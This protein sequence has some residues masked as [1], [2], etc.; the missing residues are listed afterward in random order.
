VALVR[1]GIVGCGVI[2]RDYAKRIAAAERLELAGA[3][4]LEPERADAFAAEHGCRSYATLDEL[5]ADPAIELV[6]NV[7]PPQAHATVSAAALGAG[8]HVHSEKPLALRHE[9]AAALV[10]QA[11]RQ[12][13]RLSCAPATLLGEAQQTAWKLVREGA[14]GT[15]RAV[16]A[17]ANWGRIESWHPDPTAL[18]AVGPLVDVG[19]Y[20]IALVTAMLGPVRRVIAHGA[21]LEPERT[22]R[23]GRSFR[24]GAPDFVVAT[25]ELE[26]GTAV[27]VTASFYVGGS[28]QHGLELHGD[29]GSLHLHDWAGGDSAV[30]LR[31]R[32]GDYA[33]VPLVRPATPGTDWG[34]PLVDLAEAVESGRP[35]RTGAEHAAHV[36]EI[37][38]A[39]AESI[40]SGSAVP[41]LSGF[42]QP[43]PME[44]A[45]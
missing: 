39:A 37:L 21:T 4:D 17:E 24:P 11:Q 36:V 22:T 33:P 13:V 15:V 26:S 7:T 44:W 38:A 20:P 43:R 18:Y 30:E 42:E 28:Y 2:A 10:E 41:V 6:V 23:S 8:K 1:I 25:L 19:V 14:I 32:A 40:R 16:Y 31:S 12:G 27:R 35:H 3:T 9:D 5:L 29:A 45:A 34:R